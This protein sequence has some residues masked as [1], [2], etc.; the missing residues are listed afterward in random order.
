MSEKLESQVV[1]L[2]IWDGEHLQVFQVESK[3]EE[4]AKSVRHEKVIAQKF[5]QRWTLL[6]N[7]K[8]GVRD[9]LHHTGRRHLKVSKS[10]FGHFA[11]K[12]LIE[13]LAVSARFIFSQSESVSAD[14]ISS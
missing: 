11:V 10:H 6:G 1:A 14:Q 8:A 3:A 12:Q 4:I 13:E 5:L 2:Q 7:G 9:A